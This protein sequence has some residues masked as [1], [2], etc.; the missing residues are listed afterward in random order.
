MYHRILLILIIGS[1]FISSCKD[2][3]QADFKI[4]EIKTLR[5]ID[6]TDKS[7]ESVGKISIIGD[8]NAETQGM[9]WSTKQEPT[10]SDSSAA[11]ISGQ[12]DFKVVLS[13]LEQDTKYYVRAYAITDGIASYGEEIS[14]TTNSTFIDSRDGYTYRTVT[15]GNQ[16]WMA[17]NLRFLPNVSDDPNVGSYESPFYYV[18]GYNG[19]DVD[20]AKATSNYKTY[21]VLYNW[22]AAI[23]TC[24]DGW[25]LPSDDEWKQLEIALGMTQQEVNRSLRGSNEGSKL[26]GF[27]NLWEKDDDLTSNDEFGTSGFSVLPGGNVC[28]DFQGAGESAWFWTSTKSADLGAYFR[29]INTY[30]ARINRDYRLQIKGFSVRCIKD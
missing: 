8:I 18:L 22:Q 25:H 17:E 28:G 9:C 4:A 5:I 11:D 20:E 19:T 6:I 1:I 26:S 10:I 27:T 7:A 2:D 15:I 21:G 30:G 29:S 24:P 14:F 13:N 23:Q 3:E 12:E 16:V